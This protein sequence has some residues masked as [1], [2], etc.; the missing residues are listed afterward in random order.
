ME[1]T[2]NVHHTRVIGIEGRTRTQDG[3]NIEV[4]VVPCSIPLM[5]ESDGGDSY[6]NLTLHTSEGDIGFGDQEVPRSRNQNITPNQKTAE[7]M[8]YKELERMGVRAA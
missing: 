5:L 7:A 1:T 4:A 8:L 6:V 3:Q 2:V